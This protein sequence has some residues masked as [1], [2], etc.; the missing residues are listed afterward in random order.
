MARRRCW[1]AKS[2]AGRV[3]VWTSTL[4]VTWNDLAL[5]PVFLPFIH[6]VGAT[7]AAYH[8]AAGVDDRRR[9]ACRP[10]AGR[11]TAGP[12]QAGPRWC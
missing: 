3:L 2:D 4:D 8:A 7:L 5:K 12:A 9:R 11:P 10:A 1:S 6:R